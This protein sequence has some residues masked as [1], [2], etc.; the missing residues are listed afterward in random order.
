MCD[1]VTLT[2]AATAVA[3]VSTVFGGIQQA[4]MHRYEAGIAQNNAVY[5]ERQATDA[6]TRGQKDQADLARRVAA[7]RGEQEAAFAAEGVDLGFGSALDVVGDT[8]VTGLVDQQISNDPGG[9][10]WR[11]LIPD[12]MQMFTNHFGGGIG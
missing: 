4:Q 1:P 3:T 8:T 9:D 2:I 10:R 11:R 5:A 6:E 7:V 12:A